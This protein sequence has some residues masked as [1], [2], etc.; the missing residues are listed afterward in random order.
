MLLK[1]L[2]LLSIYPVNKAYVFSTQKP[3]HSLQNQLQNE[4][5]V[6]LFEKY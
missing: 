4:N 6:A 3:Y 5:A 2:S 1:Q